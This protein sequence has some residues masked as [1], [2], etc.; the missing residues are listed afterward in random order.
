[1]IFKNY[2]MKLL[3]TT[4]LFFV[5]FS[6]SASFISAQDLNTEIPVDKDVRIGKLDNGII[7]YIRSGNFYQNFLHING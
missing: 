3:K 4:F 1:M 2:D 5:L 7:Y 6:I